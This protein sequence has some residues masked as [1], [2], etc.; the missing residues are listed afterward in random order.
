MQISD[1]LILGILLGSFLFYYIN[2]HFKKYK[3][4]RILKRAKN[5][6]QKAVTV[7]KRNGY[8]IL[9][10][11]KRRPVKIF[12]NDEPHETYVKADFIVKKYSKIYVVE[13]K[14]GNQTKPTSPL[15]RRQL[16]EYYL[17]FKPH[18]VLLLDMDKIKL[19]TIKFE[20]KYFQK[21]WI[22]YFVVFAI[23]IILGILG[24]NLAS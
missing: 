1:I 5:A 22:N 13:V 24:Y 17:V 3:I 21:D 9:D 10:I 16:L 7:L 14:T 18:G 11:Q 4:K 23:G 19:S 2:T 8:H 12:I 15:V 20:A 6:E